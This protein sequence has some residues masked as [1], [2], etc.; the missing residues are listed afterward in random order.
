MARETQLQNLQDRRRGVVEKALGLQEA[1]ARLSEDS[2]VKYA[3]GAMQPIEKRYTEITLEE[4]SRV[5]RQLEDGLARRNIPVAFRFQGS[6]TNDTHIK[7]YSDIDL[8]TLHLAY[9]DLEPPLRPSTPYAGDPAS[10]LK[11]LRQAAIGVLANAFPEVMVDASGSKAL[12]LSGGSLRRDVDVV[13]G[14]WWN[15]IEY[16]Q[17]SLEAFRGVRIYDAHS[18]QRIGNKPF[19]HN[20][21]I[22]E[23][24]A[25]CGGGLRKVCRLLKSLKYDAQPE[26][27]MSSYD[28]VSLAYAMSEQQ[29]TTENGA[30]L[31]LVANT[32]EFLRVLRGSEQLRSQMYVPNGMRKV[33]C[34]EGATIDG[35]KALHAEVAQLLADIHQ[36]LARSFKKLESSR[37]LLG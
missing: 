10:D 9:H 19:L 21:R 36:G 31:Q 33:F 12:A 11:E 23:K 20:L 13:I 24:D 29:L 18:Q 37:I 30:D 34:A 2:A 7:A 35:L 1:Y 26:V 4:G 8:L 17:T 25:R 3:I 32:E 14:N 28:L 16:E 22:A 5:R 6:T 15:N 27:P